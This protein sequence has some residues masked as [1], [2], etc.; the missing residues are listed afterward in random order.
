MTHKESETIEFKKSTAEL[1]EAVISVVAMLNKHGHGEIYFG[2]DEHDKV[3]G[4]TIGR[5]TIKEVTQAVVD[6]TEPKVYPKVEARKIEGKDC[7]VVEAKGNN[8]PYFAYGRAYLR[9]GES[10]K[11]MS[12]QELEER[13]LEKRKFLWDKEVSEKTLTDV[14]E[15][16]VKEF[17]R[18][19][20]T[21]KRVDFE[22][23][24]VK[25]TLH[26]LHLLEGNHL[27]RAA[28]VLFCDDNPLEVQAAIFAGTDKLTFLDIKSFKGNL[29]SLRQQAEVYVNGNIKWRAEIKSGPRKEIPEIPVEAIREAVGNSLCHRDY[30]NPKGNEVAIFKDRIEIYNPG[31]FPKEINPEDFFTGHEKS[32]LR[33]PLIAETMYKSKD[34]ER[35]GSGIKRIHDECVAAGVKVEFNRLKTGF[36]VVFYRPKWEEGKGLAEGL[37]EG[38]QKSKVK[39]KV[40]SRVKVIEMIAQNPSVTIPEIAAALDMSIPGIEKIIRSLK[41]EKRLRRIGP[42]KGGHW[43]ISG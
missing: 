37:A 31:L 30:S 5:M 18:K 20:K 29:F 14:N 42:D 10:N 24:D 16:A 4:M 38:G 22:F 23:V 2:I 6:N 17:M 27:L 35:W 39:S 33:N 19:A 7:I 11:A 43:E 25:T 36:V 13:I 40:K 28:E 12:P 1:K 41:E 21:A 9:V 26:K 32:I 34:I 15:E 3:V 8:G